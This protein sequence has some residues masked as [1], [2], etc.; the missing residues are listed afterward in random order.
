MTKPKVPT[1]Q[2]M[3]S[4][5]STIGEAHE[6]ALAADKRVRESILSKIELTRQCGLQIAAAKGDLREREFAAVTDFL[7]SNSIKSYLKFARANAEPITELSQA[8]A[9]VAAALTLT[10]ALPFPDGHGPQ[11]L[12]EPNFFSKAVD[13]IQKLLGLYRHYLQRFPLKD[14]RPQHVESLA[15]S[16]R[17]VAEA[18]RDLTVELKSRL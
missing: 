1:T 4:Y 9:A 15:A 11:N 12:H 17:P 6:K 16:L 3:V 5:R 14:W 13:L 8:L 7:S 18:Y 10:G 2:L